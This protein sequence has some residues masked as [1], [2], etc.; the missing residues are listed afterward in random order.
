MLAGSDPCKTGHALM[1]RSCKRRCLEGI[2]PLL[3]SP[4]ATLQQLQLHS[5]KLTAD[6]VAQLATI[7]GQ[8]RVLHLDQ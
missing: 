8:L 3:H 4:F 5:V 7:S 6:G 1:L 2:F